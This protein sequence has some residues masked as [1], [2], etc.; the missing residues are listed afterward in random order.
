MSDTFNVLHISDV[1]NEE[2]LFI[3]FVEYETRPDLKEMQSWTKSGLIELIH[4]TH[5]GRECHAIIDEEGKFDT[6]NEVNVM[7]TVKWRNYLKKNGLT[8][9]G[10]MIVGKCSV[11]TNYDLE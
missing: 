2:G 1:P 9:Y 7:A 3:D 10:D 6:S 4:V 5:N 11:L 8:A